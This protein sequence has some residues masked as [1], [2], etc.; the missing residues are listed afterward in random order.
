[1]LDP[2]APRAEESDIAEGSNAQAIVDFILLNTAAVLVVA[3]KAA[4]WKAG[5]ELAR[6]SMKEGGAKRA[7]QAFR[8]KAGLA[9][10]GLV[11]DA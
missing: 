10:A 4:D 6:K 7:L 9:L 1:M 8:D 5:V 3:G 11:A 2:L